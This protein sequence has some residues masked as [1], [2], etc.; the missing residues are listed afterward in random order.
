MRIRDD[1]LQGRIE[2]HL[3]ETNIHRL[4][5]FVDGY[6]AC[7]VDQG[8]DDLDFGRFCEWLGSVKKEFPDEGWAAKYLRDSNGDHLAA[9]KKFL[10]FVA[11]FVETEGKTSH[12]L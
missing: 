9:I 8:A 6:R 4:V 5:G 10:D 1:M 3:G 11:E 12:G 2:M 7:L